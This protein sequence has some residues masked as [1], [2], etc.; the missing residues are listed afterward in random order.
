V[1]K[2][3]AALAIN[4]GN[5]DYTGATTLSGGTT[6]IVTL[7]N[8]GAASSLGAASAA[9]GK[10][11]LDGGTLAYTGGNVTTDRGFTIS[12]ADSGISH[13]SNVTFTGTV[14]GVDG[15]SLIKSGAGTLTLS[16]TTVTI[17]GA[18]LVNHVQGGT[19]AFSGPG[20][21]VS[22]PGELYVGSV[23]NV[24]AHLVIQNSALTVANFLALGRGNGDTG[25][26]STLTAT[27]STVHVGSF[28][29]GFD[30]G[31]ATNDSDQTVTLNNTNWTTTGFT[32]LAERQNSTTNIT[33]AGN[34]VYAAT[35]RIQMAINGTAVCNFTL[36]DSASLT[37]TGG[38]FS[39]GND[40]TATMT[41]KNNSTVSTL[42]ADF[43]ISDVGTSTGTLNIQDNASVSATGIVFVGKN[44]GT[45]G[46]VN[47][48]G[49]T[50]NS[51]TYI[52]IGRRQGATGYFNI[53]GGTVNQT[54]AGAGF[55][56]G[57][58]GA[59][60][61]NVG[62]T[63]VLNI[64]GGGLYLSAEGT[65]TSNSVAHLNAG[66][67]IIAKRVVQ[68]DF[69]A[70]NYTEF[71]FN[72]GLLKAQTGSA[73]DFMSNHDLV[74]VDA[75]GAFIDSNG[76]AIT[77]SQPLVGPGSLTKQGTG[78]LTLS[79]ANTYAGNTT[80][81][82]GTLSVTSA[83]F[84][85]SGTL[86][87]ASGAVLNLGHALTDQVASLVIGGTSLPVGTY[88]AASHPG[89]IT[90]AGKLQVTGAV[91]S[92]YDTWIAGYPSIPV[93]DR[94]PGDDPDGDGAT[95]AVEFALGGTPNSGSSRPKVYP[96]VADGS[97]DVD[98]TQELL[99]TIAVRSGTP[100]FTGS[101]SPTANQDGYTYTVQG[102]TGLNGFTTV[103]VPVTA[104][105]TGLPAA[106]AGYEYRTFSL[107]GS[108]GVPTKGFM[109]VGIT[110]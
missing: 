80:V 3:T 21:T 73:T 15:G 46:T 19:L 53:T 20:Q 50:F 14:S 83:F 68:R 17:G 104:V 27:G 62:G 25:V 33:L 41:V 57:E 71:R 77:I 34:S 28:S 48:S 66:G 85:N 81:S 106:P 101:P 54:G 63:G 1:K 75:G 82:A 6:T 67:T 76:Q 32:L 61:L 100:A 12:G 38:W 86:N 8:G 72:G 26:L 98:T 45:T 94:D 36:Q 18:G 105:T 87:I 10:L 91:A 110:P 108:N 24:P 60:T 23:P 89:I 30:A 56:V 13:A 52:T 39:V 11:V 49:G 9:P 47:I 42:N 99:L 4:L 109:R 107:T 95:N 97:V 31:L 51:A 35:D 78:T 92:P 69:N 16:G 103:V 55:N 79:G 70:A 22:I 2:G 58:N 29:T 88:D 64:L 43:N 84:S 102:G 7:N 59:G 93:A 5:N 44:G 65:G 74:S 90:G 37:H 40:G 96:L